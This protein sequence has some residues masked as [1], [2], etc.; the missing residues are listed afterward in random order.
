MSDSATLDD[1]SRWKHRIVPVTAGGCREHE[2]WRFFPN[3]SRE[4]TEG[5]HTLAAIGMLKAAGDTVSHDE[6]GVDPDRSGTDCDDARLIVFV[7][8]LYCEI[9]RVK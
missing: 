3:G 8:A 5:E 1:D 7:C 6:V 9:F 2:T 4:I